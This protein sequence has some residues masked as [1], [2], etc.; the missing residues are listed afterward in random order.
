MT[1]LN[2]LVGKV[3]TSITCDGCDIDIKTSDGVQFRFIHHQD[4]CESVSLIE[5][6]EDLQSLVDNPIL[7][8][9]E[10]AC[11]KEAMGGYDESYTWTYYCLATIKGHVDLRWYGSSNGYYSE[12]VDFEKFDPDFQYKGNNQK[13]RW[14]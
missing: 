6:E 2:D 1:N 7:L 10:R 8:A 12:R 14:L 4:C 5:G 11:D 3:I 13:G 9:E